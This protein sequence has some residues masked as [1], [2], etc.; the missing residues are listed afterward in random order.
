MNTRTFLKS[1]PLLGFAFSSENKAKEIIPRII[2]PIEPIEPIEKRIE[3]DHNGINYSI[4]VTKN[5][6]LTIRH[7]NGNIIFYTNRYGECYQILCQARKGPINGGHT[8]TKRCRLEGA[9]HSH[10]DVMSFWDKEV[11]EFIVKAENELA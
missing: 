1:I 9:L 6:L 2:P 7:E 4:F 3:F 11:A 5:I 10:K 8:I